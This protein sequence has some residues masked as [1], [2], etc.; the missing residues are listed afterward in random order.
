MRRIDRKIR[1]TVCILLSNVLALSAQSALDPPPIEDTIHILI[2]KEAGLSQATLEAHIDHLENAWADTFFTLGDA[3]VSI[4]VINAGAPLI[5]PNMSSSD[6]YVTHRN[7]IHTL[8]SASVAGAPP[9]RDSLAADLVVAYV[10]EYA[11]AN[12]YVNCGRADQKYWIP[13]PPSNGGQFV[14]DPMTGLDLR[15]QDD[16]YIALVAIGQPCNVPWFFHGTSHELGHLFGAGHYEVP[17]STPAPRPGLL[18]NSKAN[19]KEQSG[20]TRM[21]TVGI[22]PADSPC[23][24]IICVD[25]GVWSD[26][27][28]DWNNAS[29]RN[30]D[31]IDLTAESVAHYRMGVPNFGETDTCIDGIDND[32]DGQTDSDEDPECMSGNS[33]LPPP[34]PP[35]S[36]CSAT[37]VPHRLYVRLSQTCTSSLG[38]HYQVHWEHHCASHVSEYEV[39]AETPPDDDLTYRWSVPSRFTDAFIWNGSAR[40]KIRACGTGGCSY[41]TEPGVIVTDIC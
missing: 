2:L 9:I 31:A 14:E 4:T 24:G 27:S 16:S 41:W 35:P 15:G 34:P 8:V 11:A 33:E 21:A 10:D 32:G 29:R 40:I 7:A 23:F 3:P 36:T 39:W 18:A 26:W 12:P 19:A 28:S 13:E 5:L 25:D 17:P 38:S 6:D 1:N 37:I 30:T 22:S 20:Y